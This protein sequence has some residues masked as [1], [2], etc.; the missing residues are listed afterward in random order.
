MVAPIFNPKE[1]EIIKY[2]PPPSTLLLVA[3][4]EIAKAVGMVTICP[5]NIIRMA[6][7]KPTVPTAKPNLKNRMAPSIVDMAVKKTGAVPNLVFIVCVGTIN[8]YIKKP[9]LMIFLIVSCCLKNWFLFISIF[10][11]NHLF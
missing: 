8:G 4:S 1:R 9:N 3:I 2:S 5:N 6:P 10:G 7:Q 11:A